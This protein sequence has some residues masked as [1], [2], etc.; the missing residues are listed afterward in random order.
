MKERL[1]SLDMLRGLDMLLLVA[2]GPLVRQANAAWNFASPGFIG[3]FRHNYLGFTLWDIIMPLF[4]FMCGAAVPFA[5]GRRLKDGKAVFWKHVLGRVVLLWFL[6]MLV[7]GKLAELD[8]LTFNPFSNTLESIAVGYLITAAVMC[9][10][11]RA[12]QVAAPAVLALAYTVCLAAGG[13]YSEFGNFAY[14]VDH[15][16]HGAIFPAG[17]E[18]LLK[19]SFYTWYL[20]SLMFGAMTLCGYHA[21]EMLRS[22][23]SKRTKAV[24]LF[25]YAAGLLALGF[26]V[27]P[28]IPVV[29]PIFTL[30]FTALAMGW[31]VLALAVLYVLNDILM[32]RRGTWLVI[33]FGQVALTAY[34][35][36]HFFRPVLDAFAH[37]V[38]KGVLPHV[39]EAA[40][41]FVLEVLIVL[42]TVLV[43]LFWR[44][45]KSMGNQCR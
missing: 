34:F 31:S 39:A 9:V 28:W 37:T 19:P 1:F 29:K 17:H 15:A 41:P 44:Q 25:A 38:A 23:W 16:I 13:D 12:F 36:S 21:A 32:L 27:S 20:T 5:L 35:V 11:S 43:M 3:Q 7:Q 10:P 18:R 22:A 40:R 26:G 42:G 4:I 33:L 6:G 14:K 2:V 30:S 45:W 24:A 8:P